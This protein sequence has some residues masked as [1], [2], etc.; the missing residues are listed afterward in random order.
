M[1]GRFTHSSGNRIVLDTL[2][3]SAVEFFFFTC[4]RTA[5][6]PLGSGVGDIA[7]R[8]SIWLMIAIV[9]GCLGPRPPATPGAARPE[10]APD[11]DMIVMI[12]IGSAHGC[13]F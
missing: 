13:L 8:E 10:D 1:V 12:D 6:A 11:A 3:V 2:G 5:E 4:K 7:R 9:D